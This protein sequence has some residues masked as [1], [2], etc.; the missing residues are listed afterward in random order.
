MKTIFEKIRDREIP[1]K[2]L[3]ETE[4]T[5]A[6]L[7]IGQATKGHTLVITKMPFENLEATPLDVLYDIMASTKRAVSILNKAFN[8]LGY[9]YLS[10]QHSVSGQTV[11]HMH[12]HII[13]RYKET[14]IEI[15]FKK[16][17]YDLLEVF[18]SVTPFI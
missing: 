10:N 18:D 8:P 13:P 16:T 2:F 4:H 7:D 6:I 1:A 14:D 9:N 5:M 11:M 3:F 15:H 17:N 12:M